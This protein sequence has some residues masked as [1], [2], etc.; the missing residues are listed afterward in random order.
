MRLGVDSV[1]TR[2]FPTPF[3]EKAVSLSPDGRW[4]AYESDET[5]RD[6]VYVRSFPDVDRSRVLVSSDGGIQPVWSH[7][8]RELFYVSSRREL[9]A[10]RI[11]TE[12]GVVVLD[13]SVLFDIGPEFLI[14]WVDQYAMYDVMPDDQA[15]LLMRRAETIEPEF[16]IVPNWFGELRGQTGGG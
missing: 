11:G 16:I 7:G 9:V 3:D 5:G 1:A 15:F 12:A 6:E 4:L 10:V 8:G 2:L 14:E 13:R